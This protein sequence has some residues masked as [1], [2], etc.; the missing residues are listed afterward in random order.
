[1][2]VVKSLYD[3][4][5]KFYNGNFLSRNLKPKYHHN[6]AKSRYVGFKLM[7][8]L[9]CVILQSLLYICAKWRTASAV[10]RV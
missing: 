1:M 3:N 2:S 8:L 9:S 10:S 5:E 6:I 7:W 4:H